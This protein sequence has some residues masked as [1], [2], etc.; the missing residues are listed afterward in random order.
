MYQR[1]L[2]YSAQSALIQSLVDVPHA[3]PYVQRMKNPNDT[4]PNA[5]EWDRRDMCLT[6]P[7]VGALL[8][9]GPTNTT[10]GS[11]AMECRGDECIRAVA[12]V[13]GTSEVAMDGGVHVLKVR[14]TLLGGADIRE[15][16]GNDRP[17]SL[18]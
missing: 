1:P 11:L 3:L 9:D 6:A 8:G 17:F 10:E 2:S 18:F 7:S 15:S 12:S 13:Y 14:S 16:A 5:F 4:V